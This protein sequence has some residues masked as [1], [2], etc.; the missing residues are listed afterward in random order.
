MVNVWG[1]RQS[2]TVHCADIT[3]EL[4]VCIRRRACA[5]ACIR[6]EFAR[7]NAR[8]EGNRA[9]SVVLN[10]CEDAVRFSASANS[11]IRPTRKKTDVR[12]N[13]TYWTIYRFNSNISRAEFVNYSTYEFWIVS[14]WD[15]VHFFY[16]KK[17]K[18][19]EEEEA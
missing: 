19:E 4:G 1:V 9:R 11:P 16:S 2:S 10:F 15:N 18:E 12:D 13:T 5:S 6:Y 3:N 17:K 14:A 7:T 8:Y